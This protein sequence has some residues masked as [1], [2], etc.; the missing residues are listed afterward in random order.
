MLYSY[1]VWALCPQDSH[2]N[3]LYETGS[4]LR[5]R[6]IYKYNKHLMRIYIY[7]NVAEK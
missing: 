4:I 7:T 6:D 1:M 5:L 2:D 3:I